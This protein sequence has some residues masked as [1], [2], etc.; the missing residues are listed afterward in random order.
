MRKSAFVD[1]QFVRFIF[2]TPHL[3]FFSFQKQNFF[4]KGINVVFSANTHLA[5]SSAFFLQVFF[6]LSTFLYF[7]NYKAKFKE[8]DK[9]KERNFLNWPQ[10][11]LHFYWSW[12]TCFRLH[13][14]S[15]VHE[16]DDYPSKISNRTSIASTSKV[17]TIEI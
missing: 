8:I 17:L 3:A 15:Y 2:F 7:S 6:V 5:I 14:F 13:N 12:R 1:S 9:Q 16:L 11:L 10:I 4:S